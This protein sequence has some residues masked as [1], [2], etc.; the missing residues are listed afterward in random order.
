[1]YVTPEQIQAANKAVLEAT[2]SLAATQFAA[3]QKL[4]NLNV[5]TV[6]AVFDDSISNSK[7]LL[8]ARDATEFAAL[9]NTLAAPALER[10][11]A[12]SKGVCAV[13]TEAS[14]EMSKVAEKQLATWNESVT[15]LLDQASKNAPAG[16]DFGFAAVKSLLAAGSS[17]YGNISQ[18]SRQAGEVANANIAEA[19][20][21]AKNYASRA[22]RAG[23]P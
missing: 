16:S 12:Y 2:L 21:G 3:I 14:T 6:K 9:Q 18:A 23:Q 11:A 17:A 5:S 20:A 19:A 8:G 22:A 13:A 1:M 15:S 4:V 7:A 10:A